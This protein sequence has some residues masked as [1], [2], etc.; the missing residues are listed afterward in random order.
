[1]TIELCIANRAA[2]RGSL[3]PAPCNCYPALIWARA[4]Y[5][6]WICRGP[7]GLTTRYTVAAATRLVSARWP[8]KLGTRNLRN[9]TVMPASVGSRCGRRRKKPRGTARLGYSSAFWKL[10]TLLM[11]RA[12]MN[13][14]DRSSAQPAA[15]DRAV[16]RPSRDPPGRNVEN[17]S[18]AAPTARAEQQCC[19][20][21]T[22]PSEA[23]DEAGD[24][25][26]R[27]GFGHGRLNGAL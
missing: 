22:G 19:V 18:P 24:E 6:C 16:I 7:N 21:C 25:K 4:L 23:S 26:R 9:L 11:S 5:A 1:V 20:A 8:G 10:M 14:F 17:Q 13:T 3:T 2:W 27:G 12:C 15:R